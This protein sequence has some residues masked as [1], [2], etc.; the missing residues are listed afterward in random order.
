VRGEDG[1]DAE[2]GQRRIEIR[3]R[4]TGASEPGE[5]LCDRVVKIAVAGGPLATTQ[6]PDPA[7][8]L[9][10][11]DQLEVQ[12]EGGDDGLGR[13]QVE[14]VELAFQAL[15]LDR[16]V[17]LAQ[18]DGGQS[19]ATSAKRSGPACSAMTWPS[20][21]PSSRTSRASGSRAPADPMPE[22]SARSAVE[23]RRR[24]AAPRA[25][26]TAANREGW[27]ATKRG[28]RRNLSRSQPSVPL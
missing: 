21:A 10:E 2:A 11:V 20:N 3:V 27:S 24:L 26:V 18:G 13:A 22:G 14:P 23:A 25:R 1:R 12:G 16:V 28:R 6:G 9:G 15:P 4:A 5:G 7:A 19:E 8:R 17:A